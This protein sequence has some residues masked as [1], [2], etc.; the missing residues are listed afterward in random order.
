MGLFNRK[1]KAE[2]IEPKQQPI[3]E[4][5]VEQI[6]KDD[7]VVDEDLMSEEEIAN[8]YGDA[9]SDEE[10]YEPTIS[11]AQPVIKKEVKPIQQNNQ[12]QPIARPLVQV[13]QPKIINKPVVVSQEEML[14]ILYEKVE[15]IEYA[16][17]FIVNEIKKEKNE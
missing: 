11:Q 17:A 4:P 12:V 15:A 3:P 5:V 7:F 16:I 2:Q 8:E 13:S 9:P 6:P 14:N 10:M 1:K